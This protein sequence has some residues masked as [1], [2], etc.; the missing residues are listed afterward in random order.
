MNEWTVYRIKDIAKY[1][2]SGTTPSS[3]IDRYYNSDD[4]Y[5]INTGDFNN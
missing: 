1:I 5:W 4:Y 3:K 2:G